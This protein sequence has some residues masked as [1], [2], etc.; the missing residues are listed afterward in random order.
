MTKSFCRAE[1]RS[2]F[3]RMRCTPCGG[4]LPSSA[5]SRLI[6]HSTSDM[7]AELRN[8]QDQVRAAAAAGTPLRLRGSGSKDFYGQALTRRSARHARLCRRRRLRADRTGDHRPLRHAARRDRVAAGRT[9]P[10]A[11]LRAAAFRPG[12]HRRRLRLCRTVRPAPAGRRQR[13]RFRARREADR[14]SCR[15]HA[16]R[17]AGDEERRRLRRLAP[18]VRCARHAR[19]DRRGFAEGAAAALRGIDAA[20][21]A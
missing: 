9:R 21:P 6:R 5:A 14:R 19:A 20:V 12:G 15:G 4:G 17:R 8:L 3:R 18:G 2:A 1:K 16:V 7:E 10:D 11:G 13:A